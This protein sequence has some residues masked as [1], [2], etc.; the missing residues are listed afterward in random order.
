M[1]Q[2]YFLFYSPILVTWYLHIL[3]CVGLLIPI[4]CGTNSCEFESSGT[5]K[6]LSLYYCWKFTYQYVPHCLGFYMNVSRL[7]RYLHYI[8]NKNMTVWLHHRNKTLHDIFSHTSLD[9][10]LSWGWHG[11]FHFINWQSVKILIN[12][13]AEIGNTQKQSYR[14]LGIRPSSINAI[15]SL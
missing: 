14:R 15:I 9:N 11:N 4:Q 5:H 12:C 3:R 6:M 1:H 2:I 8:L 7:R 13:L 10:P